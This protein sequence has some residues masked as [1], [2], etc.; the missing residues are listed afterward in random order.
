MVRP[1]QIAIR[2][3]AHGG[4]G[5]GAPEGGGPTWFVA[6]ALPGELVEAEAEHTAK[7]FVR[8]RLL[9]VSSPAPERVTPPCPQIAAGCGGCSWQHVDT[10]RQLELKRRIVADQLRALVPSEDFVRTGEPPPRALYYRRRA[11]LHYVRDGDELRLGFFAAGSRR[12][13]DVPTCMVLVPALD[14]AVQRLRG[15][16]SVLPHEGEVHGVTDGE[17]AILGL[18]GVRPDPGTLAALE[19]VLGG[20]LVGL[21]VRGGRQ[22]ATLGRPHLEIDGG[23]GL[24]PIFASALGFAQAN[25]AVNRALVRHVARAAKAEGA[26]V[27]ELFCGAGNLTR[28]LARAAQRVWAVDEDREAIGLLRKLSQAEGLPINAKKS[29]AMNLVA[30]IAAGTSRYDVVVLDPPRRGLGETAAAAVGVVA[31]SRIVY[32]SCDPATLARDLRVLVGAGFQLSDVTVFDMMPMTPE[33]EVVAT[34]VRKRGAS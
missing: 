16:A 30:K 22:S 29:S 28:G 20:S 26:R 13:L 1:V 18:P 8:G 12:V 21:E 24:P 19:G 3:L 25:A 32:V 9:T 34:L 33:V 10:A 7:R 23:L 6:G 31:Q 2:S 4:E 14:A 27:L 5:V 17:A 15:A 11:R